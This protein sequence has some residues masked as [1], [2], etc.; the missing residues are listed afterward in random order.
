LA[1]RIPAR[2]STTE[3]RKFGVT[4][5]AAFLAITAIL[6]WRDHPTA[7]LVTGSLGGAL[8][9]A[10]LLIP[11][12]LGPVERAWMALALAI[13]KVTTPVFMGVLYFLVLLPAGAIMRLVG[14]RP[15]VHPVG[16]HGYWVL[17]ARED[18]TSTMDRQF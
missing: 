13:S 6:W 1:R 11:S 16:E 9:L 12:H 3:G 5:G 17:R 18:T 14:K 2:L 10:G 4:V 7:M 15:L 8:V